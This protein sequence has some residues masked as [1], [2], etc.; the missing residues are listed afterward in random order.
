M[1]KEFKV[2][3][4]VENWVRASLP[5]LNREAEEEETVEEYYCY[6]YLLHTPP[7][8]KHLDYL[9]E[10]SGGE[11]FVTWQN[12]KV[13]KQTKVSISYEQQLSKRHLSLINKLFN[14]KGVM[15]VRG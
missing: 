3:D 1:T 6:T 7:T 8:D 15:E 12:N 13:K 5:F 2:E 14:V 10:L 4:A 11:V 9:F